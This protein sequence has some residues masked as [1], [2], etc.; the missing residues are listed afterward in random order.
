MPWSI[1]CVGISIHKLHHDDSVASL[2]PL[3]NY[4]YPFYAK[5]SRSTESYSGA[6]TWK[7][8][9]SCSRSSSLISFTECRFGRAG[10][11]PLRL[12]IRTF[13]WLRTPLEK[14]NEEPRSIFVEACVCASASR[15]VK[16]NL[17]FPHSMTLDL[18]F[19]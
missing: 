18:I 3:V 15:R 8:V 5:L 12:N 19:V 17:T 6:S 2:E 1:C 13:P 16:H 11:S 9:E 7:A 4:P 10:L 14:K